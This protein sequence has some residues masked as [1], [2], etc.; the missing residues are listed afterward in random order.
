MKQI[1]ASDVI[2][3]TAH[4]EGETLAKLQMSGACSMADIARRVHGAV[5]AVRG[6]INVSLRN[7]SQGWTHR[8]NMCAV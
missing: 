8:Y 6:M 1:N 3:V 7:A 5:G 2:Y 4:R